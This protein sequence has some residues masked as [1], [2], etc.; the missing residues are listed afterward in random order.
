MSRWK[1]ACILCR[2]LSRNPGRNL[3]RT[4][5]DLGQHRCRAGLSLRLLRLRA[6][7][8]R[9]LRLLRPRLV[10]QWTSSSEQALGTTVAA[11]FTATSTTAT[12]PTTATTVRSPS[13]ASQPFNHFHGNEA[14]DPQ[15][16]IG[17]AG[18]EP[19]GEHSWWLLRRRTSRRRR[20]R[21]KIT[22][23]IS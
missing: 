19:G 14:H 15:G 13:A 11:D 17:N 2:G 20:S 10:L 21:P 6:V 7:Q 16:H 18:H 8:L 22:W 23:R 9:P 1:F 5:A 3:R 4:R 12:T